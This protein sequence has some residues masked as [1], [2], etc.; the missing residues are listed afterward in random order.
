[1]REYFTLEGVVSP[2]SPRDRSDRIVEFGIGVLV[3]L[4]PLVILLVTLAFLVY[5][6]DLVL[7]RV[8]LLEFLELYLLELAL[9]GIFSYALYRLTLRLVERQL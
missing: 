8:T 7:G 4:F 6:E 5:T 2:M 3:F 1:M 9:F